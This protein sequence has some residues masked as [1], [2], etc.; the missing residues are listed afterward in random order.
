MTGLQQPSTARCRVRRGS[1]TGRVW[2]LAE[3]V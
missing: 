3:E 2:S 1:Y